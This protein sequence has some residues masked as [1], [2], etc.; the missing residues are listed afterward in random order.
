[1]DEKL[2]REFRALLPRLRRF[3]CGLTGSTA[4]GDDLLQ[5]T[6]ERA[7]RNIDKWEPGTRLDSWL[8]RIARNLHLNDMRAQ[9]VRSRHLST[10]ETQEGGKEVDGARALESRMTLAKV[11]GFVQRLPEEQRAVLLLFCVEG[12]SY[13][14]TSAVLGIPVGTVTSRLGRARLALRDFMREPAHK[15]MEPGD[16]EA[17]VSEAGEP[18]RSERDEAAR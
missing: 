7:I 3:A 11:R 16:S 17:G 13:R 10:L 4:D 12:L 1:M 18:E 6:C 5:A 2:E 15:G 9:G 8:F 14:E